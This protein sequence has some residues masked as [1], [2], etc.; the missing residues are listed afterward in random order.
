MDEV[1]SIVRWYGMP[2][3]TVAGVVRNMGTALI[4]SPSECTPATEEQ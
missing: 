2:E 4:V 3:T 1:P